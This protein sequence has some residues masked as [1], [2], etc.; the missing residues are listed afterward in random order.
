MNP[1]QEFQ[2]HKITILKD[3]VR[4]AIAGLKI[5]IELGEEVFKE[6]HQKPIAETRMGRLYLDRLEQDLI[7]VKAALKKLQENI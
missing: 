6:F 5:G 3:D 4:A 2:P 1:I 7:C